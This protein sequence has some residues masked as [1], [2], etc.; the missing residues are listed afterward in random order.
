MDKQNTLHTFVFTLLLLFITSCH[1]NGNGKNQDLRQKPRLPAVAGSFYPA[2]STRLTQML[3]NMFNDAKKPVEGEEHAIIIPHAG[4]VFSGKVAAS[5]VNQ[6]NANKQYENIFLLGSCHRHTYEGA[7]I[8][9]R[10]NYITPLGSV[11]VNTSLAN[12]LIKTH[13]VFHYQENAHTHEHSLEVEL[14]LL[15]YKL[16]Q[17]FQIVPIL[18]GS[19]NINTCKQIAKALK[20]YF[21]GNNIFVIS[22]DLSHYPRYQDAR[23]VDMETINAVLSGNPGRLTSTIRKH[24]QQSIPQLSTAMCGWSS[25]LSLQYLTKDI[26]GISYKLLEYINSGDTKYGDKQKVVGYAAIAITKQN[27]CKHKKDISMNEFVITK[28]EQKALLTIA[29]NAIEARINSN[30]TPTIDKSSLTET[31]K[32]PLGAFV[33]LKKDG[34]LRGCIGRFDA[35]KPLYKT[36]NDMA[37]SASTKDPRFPP[38]EKKEIDDLHIEISVLSPM[39]KIDSADEIVMGRHGVYIKKGMRSGT[40]LPQVA[41]STGWTKEEFLGHLCRDKAGIGWSAWKDT[42]TEVYIYEAKVFEE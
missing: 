5:G 14:P 3:Q 38:V 24:R 9:N 8:Y 33:T 34:R 21:G 20:P 41:E 7:S 11:K 17:D 15:Q 32:Q 23:E 12:K 2:D 29:R 35:T 26:A 37:V 18:I 39:K 4:Y 22:T 13:A 28:A 31:L 6:L 25:V 19:H 27:T 10:G 36:I 16:K 30:P 1:S 40:F 42:D